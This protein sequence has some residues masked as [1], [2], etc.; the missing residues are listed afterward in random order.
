MARCIYERKK[1]C[2]LEGEANTSSPGISTPLHGKLKCWTL[3]TP[4]THL[5][6]P[7]YPL[8]SGPRWFTIVI[9]S[10][11]IILFSGY[12]HLFIYLF[13]SW[14]QV[15]LGYWIC[16]FFYLELVWCILSS[17]QNNPAPSMYRYMIHVWR[18]TALYITIWYCLVYW[19]VF[20]CTVFYVRSWKFDQDARILENI[21]STLDFYLFQPDYISW[22]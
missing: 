14:R 20:E 6:P 5:S 17:L 21:T 3:G 16:F 13:M 7:V 2:G 8:W 22:G 1:I 18:K 19:R 9:R 10:I 15:D 4:T 12:F 11:V